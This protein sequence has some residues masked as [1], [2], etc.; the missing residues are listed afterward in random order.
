MGG[1]RSG[2]RHRAATPEDAVEAGPSNQE[3]QAEKVPQ[4]VWQPV[5]VA[6]HEGFPFKHW[7]L[8][9]EN[10]KHPSKSFICN[11][12]GDAGRFRYEQTYKNAHTST[13]LV[14]IIHV[15]YVLSSNLK[16]LRDVAENIPIQNNDPAWNC[17]DFAWALLEELAATGL[18]D[19]D[20]EAYKNGR[21]TVWSKM[22]GLI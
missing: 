15:G 16:A 21:K 8:F 7:G 1:L 13:T 14:D 11:V 22:E 2:H 9:V 6:I 20:D 19:P 4:D 10:E 5:W 3:A 17:Q 12:Q 18:V